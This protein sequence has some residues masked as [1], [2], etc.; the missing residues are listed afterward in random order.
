MRCTAE[1]TSHDV[2]GVTIFRLVMRMARPVGQHLLM[3]YRRSLGHPFLRSCPRR[4]GV[5]SGA[6][7]DQVVYLALG[8]LGVS[9]RLYTYST[10]GICERITRRFREPTLWEDA[11]NSTNCLIVKRESLTTEPDVSV[12]PRMR[13]AFLQSNS[14][15]WKCSCDGR[16]GAQVG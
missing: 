10:A 9:D 4:L 7:V 12:C 14:G 6:R 5:V 16:E 13:K 11:L 15:T 2:A 1:S 8:K 3:R